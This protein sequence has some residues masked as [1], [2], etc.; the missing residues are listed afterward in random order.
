MII[1]QFSRWKMT[2][3]WNW[4]WKNNFPW[5]TSSFDH[6]IFEDIIQPKAQKSSKIINPELAVKPSI[7]SDYLEIQLNQNRESKL[8]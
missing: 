3:K 4:N 6:T 5:L 7:K 8:T 2:S 1:F